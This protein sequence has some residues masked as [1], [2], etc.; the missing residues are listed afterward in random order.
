MTVGDETRA[1]APAGTR[2]IQA[3]SATLTALIET[4]PWGNDTRTERALRTSKARVMRLRRAHTAQGAGRA[5]GSGDVSRF[6]GAATAGLHKAPRHVTRTAADCHGGE[7]RGTQSQASTRPERTVRPATARRER[8]R[9]CHAVN[10]HVDEHRQRGGCGAAAQGQ[11]H[12]QAALAASQ[13][14]SI[15]RTVEGRALAHAVEHQL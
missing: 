14:R 10:R 7:R 8:R 11:R 6:S 15:S 3:N 13:C 2:F 12:Q 4:P 9:G 5:T 1:R